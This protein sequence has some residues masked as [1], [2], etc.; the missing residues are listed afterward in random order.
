[1]LDLRPIENFLDLLLDQPGLQKDVGVLNPHTSVSL[2]SNTLT[3]LNL[4][5][6]LKNLRVVKALNSA[7]AALNR[8]Q[9]ETNEKVKVLLKETAKDSRLFPLLQQQQQLLQQISHPA[10]P[11]ML[12][13]FEQD[14]R[15]YLA[16]QW[17]E[18]QPIAE[19][20]AEDAAKGWGW[21]AELCEAV[22][23]I[24]GQNALCL[25]LLPANLVIKKDGKLA[26]NDF[27]LLQKWPLNSTSRIPSSFNVAPEVYVSPADVGLAADVYA[28]GAVWLEL[29]TNKPLDQLK[30]EENSKRALQA[31]AEVLPATEVLPAL[32]RL[33]GRAVSRN[34][35]RR[36][37]NTVAM[38]TAITLAANDLEAASQDE[39]WQRL[40]NLQ[41]LAG[42][43]DIGME[44]ENNEDAFFAGKY[45]DKEGKI[46]TVAMLADGMGGR[47]GGEVASQVTLDI[48]R[49]VVNQKIYNLPD[50]VAAH[51][52]E[53]NLPDYV[54][55]VWEDALNQASKSVFDQALRE[56]KLKSMGS[57]FVGGLILGN[58]AYIANVGD[59]RAY[60]IKA[61]EN[62]GESLILQLSEEHSRLAELRR[63][64]KRITPQEESQAR[65][66]LA[67]N[68]GYRVTTDIFCDAYPLQD[69]DYLLLCSD[70]LTDALSDEQ[71][72]L[73]LLE[74]HQKLLEACWNL[75]NT[76]NLRYGRDNVTVLLYRHQAT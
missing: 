67:R 13:A 54:C 26:I 64:I 57:T 66:I 61:G 56:P 73:L 34:P 65:G 37:P 11:K 33:V 18:G 62:K 70:G 6:K 52:G 25:E 69:G 44:R 24:N 19:A 51:L 42:W 53:V 63:K 48:T 12:Q 38:G 49:R 35:D 29:L 30:G 5:T 27:S 20:W 59:S 60:L 47:E 75:I 23:A 39:D 22:A 50:F 14:N 17:Q 40:S 9:A 32:N 28:V 15:F 31:L 55:S 72:K 21:L 41:N 58:Y 43:T 16:L 1:M 46:F 2:P 71:I 3:L 10:I 76:V 4:D 8:Y 7:P 36:Y 68:V 45:T 74:N